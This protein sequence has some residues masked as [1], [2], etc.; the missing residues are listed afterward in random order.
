MPSKNISAGLS[1]YI[2]V[3]GEYERMSVDQKW[4]YVLVILHSILTRNPALSISQISH[5]AADMPIEIIQPH[6]DYL[7]SIRSVHAFQV[8]EVTMYEQFLKIKDIIDIREKE[9]GNKTYCFT[10]IKNEN[11]HMVLIQELLKD[12]HEHSEPIGGIVIPIE[13]LDNFVDAML[14]VRL[15][16]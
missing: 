6:L 10:E 1:T 2:F 7:V 15:I 11:G 13:Q 9:I 4:E 3:Q 14:D 8:G 16:T 12:Q 5:A